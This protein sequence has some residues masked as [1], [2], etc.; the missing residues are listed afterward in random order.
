MNCIPLFSE[1]WPRIESTRPRQLFFARK[2]EPIIHHEILNRIDDWLGV[3]GPGDPEARNH[4][5]QNMFDYLDTF[6]E[7][8]SHFYTLVNF[9]C[10]HFLISKPEL[11]HFKFT[12][13]LEVTLHKYKDS[14]ESFLI[15][16]EVEDIQTGYSSALELNV[17]FVEEIYSK[18]SL[19]SV[20]SGTEFD[21]K[22]LVFRNFLRNFGEKSNVSVRFQFISGKKDIYEFGWFDPLGNLVAVN[23][24]RTNE[25]EGI[26]N[27]EHKLSAPLLPGVWTVVC[28][29]DG[30]LL[31]THWFLVLP[32]QDG[33]P[34]YQ[35][36]QPLQSPLSQYWNL[37]AEEQGLVYKELQQ[38]RNGNREE[39]LKKHIPLFYRVD[40][41]CSL[42]ALPGFKIC[43]DTSWS[44]RVQDIYTLEL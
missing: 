17:A 5:W 11:V 2:F 38:L 37:S 19:I 13:A 10:K 41:S 42:S 35:P 23:Q 26:E 36:G 29:K 15:L 8:K 20:K 31:H 40:D 7:Q 25:T 32:D 39:W 9:L 6:P 34:G 44:S 24:V 4:Y 22:E 33:E 12:R 14:L 21:P 18:T 30:S 1:D 3:Q 27:L 28:V 43:K 16:F